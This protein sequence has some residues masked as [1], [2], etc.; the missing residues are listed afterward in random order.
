MVR[1]RV[2]AFALWLGASFAST[3]WAQTTPT[4][5][6]QAAGQAATMPR[7]AASS[8]VNGT[9][10]ADIIPNY[11][12]ADTANRSRFDN[13]RGNNAPAGNAA[14]SACA[15]ATDPTC[16]AVQTLQGSPD[17]GVLF[18]IQN[19]DPLVVR[20]NSIAT[21]AGRPGSPVPDLGSIGATAGE[22]CQTTTT[23]T[24]AVTAEEICTETRLAA[25]QGC[26]VG[27]TVPVDPD[28]IY[29]CLTRNASDT[30]V[31]CAVGRVISVDAAARY[32]CDQQDRSQTNASCLAG[33]NV[34]V[35]A[36]TQYQCEVRPMEERVNTCTRTLDLQCPTP[37][38]GCDS[39]GIVPG[40]VTGDMAVSF[41]TV[42]GGTYALDF[43]SAANDIWHGY[44]GVVDRNLTFRINRLAEITQFRLAQ[45][46]FDDWIRIILNG[47]LV[48]VGPFGGDRLELYRPP[49][50][51]E[52]ETD[53]GNPRQC[54]YT[55]NSEMGGGYYRCVTMTYAGGEGGYNESNVTGYETCTAT[56][57]GWTCT[58]FGGNDGLVQYC[59]DAS[60]LRFA[61]LNTSWVQYPNIDL[62]PF[63]VEGDNLLEMR[64]IIYDGG[65][66]FIRI[67]S[68]M[69]CP[70]ICTDNWITNCGPLEARTR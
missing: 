57:G 55:Y 64:V 10:A 67:H 13:G 30:N 18:P 5:M 31:S 68:R 38:D 12:A 7:P 58:P 17:R 23:T 3:L 36:N 54:T 8:V 14:V 60:C 69:I 9:R 35:T 11:G 4:P 22:I 62:R 34:V 61:E 2:S 37:A 59:G 49:P 46:N 41:G 45:A 32:Q 28:Y 48:Y 66:G 26:Q 40:S 63:L 51:F 56:A 42:G 50:V 20:S 21:G 39:G 1:L 44:P 43:G 24:P 15:S 6:Q 53:G 16:N 25:Y 29:Q 19:N 33:R 27:V 65:E 52:P 70:V 47:H